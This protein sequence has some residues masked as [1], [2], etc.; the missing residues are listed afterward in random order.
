MCSL[1]LA[2][3]AQKQKNCR[4]L[5]INLVLMMHSKV[6]FEKRKEFEKKKGNAKKIS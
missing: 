3:A 1:D 6:G 2:K 5:K 4:K